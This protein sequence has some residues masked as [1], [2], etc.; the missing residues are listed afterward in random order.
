MRQVRKPAVAGYFYPSEPDKLK[1][2]IE[3]LLAESKPESDYQ[4]I[5]GIVSPHA[6]YIYS[7]RTAAFG[8]N[9]V[10]NRNY[11]TV[12]I[13]SPSHREYFPGISVYDGNYYET[14]LGEIELNLK[15][16]EELTRESRIIFKGIEGHRQEHAI[17]VQ[18]PFLQ[19]VMKDFTILP[20]VIGDQGDMFVNELAS[21]LAEVADDKTLVIASSDLSHYYSG[22]AAYKL[23]SVV[24]RHISDFN[25]DGLQN[26]LNNGNCEA[27]GGGA[28][29]AM[30]KAASILNRKKSV[31]LNHS[32]S[33]DTTGDY[34]EVVG[35]ISAA[36]YGED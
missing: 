3:N 25:Y 17:E 18:L 35:Y 23:D 21:K 8:Y 4:N 34:N 6:G 19:T 13:L 30:M 36:I 16:V 24:E 22:D 1:R 10:R 14:P 26:D 28:I 27:C 29:V 20:I 5:F 7:G 12:V 15:M 2:Q 32:N 9:L 33:G 31:V 11:S